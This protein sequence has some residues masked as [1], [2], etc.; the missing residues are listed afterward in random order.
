MSYELSRFGKKL[1]SRSG[2]LELMEDLGQA[3]AGGN[4]MIMMGGGNPGHIPE[5]E[6]FWRKRMKAMLRNG[7]E[8]DSMLGN[9]DTPQGGITFLNEMAAFL[10]REYGWNVKPANIALTNG[11]QNT[12]FYLFNMFAGDMGGGRKKKIVLPFVPEYIGY[13]DQGLDEGFF[14]SFRPR[15]EYIDD[16]T[17]KYHVDFDN[18]TIGD[19]AGAVCVSRPANPTGN[20][21]TDSEIEKLLTLCK[22]KNIPLMVDNAYG[23]PFPDVIFTEAKLYWDED[24][25]LSFSLSKLGL[26]GTRT[27][28]VVAREEVIQAIS[29]VNAIVSLASGSVGQ[30]MFLPLLKNGG[31]QK[32]S[33][34]IIRPFYLK[35]SNEVV[36][37]LKKLLPESLPYYIHRNEGAFFIWIW[38][39]GM[40]T[41]SM[42]LYERLKRKQVLVIPGSY[43]F[44]GLD[45]DWEHSRECI[46]ITIS[47]DWNDIL[48]GL[49]II[50]GEIKACYE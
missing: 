7:R 39:K 50:A 11:S 46:R 23:M 43:F 19:D 1:T 12:F 49:E 21:L 16:H 32:L 38:L 48:R 13:A 9:Y 41:T 27:G 26:P 45:E 17:Y 20:V 6:K 14:Q 2:I 31:I 42:E 44:P 36:T 40:K 8:F 5:V 10:R 47:Q 22:G 4:K 30:A 28:I 18:L 24:V 37:I 29:A 25:I 34:D 35:R 33:R 15:I 3:M